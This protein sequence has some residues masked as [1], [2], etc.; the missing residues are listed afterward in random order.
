MNIILKQIKLNNKITCPE[1]ISNF[2][3]FKLLDN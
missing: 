1:Y 2:T 3:T